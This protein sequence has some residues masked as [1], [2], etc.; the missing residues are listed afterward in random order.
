MKLSNP[1]KIDFDTKRN[2]GLDILRA[3]AIFFV[4][5]VHSA[6][7][8]KPD[9]RTLRILTIFNLDGVMLFFVLSGFLIG[10][11]L[12]RQFEKDK[13]N[14]KMLFKFWIRRWFR[15]LPNYFLVLTILVILGY[16]Y[17]TIVNFSAIKHY[18]Y[19]MANFD[20]AI[21]S[22]LFPESWS[23]AVEEWFYLLIP[24]FIFILV[25]LCRF[26]PK[27]SVLTVAVS[28]IVITTV[29]R[30]FRF[31]HMPGLVPTQIDDSFRKPVITRLDSLMFGV[32]GAFLAYYYLS[33]WKKYKKLLFFI[34]IILIYSNF[35]QYFG[36]FG[37]LY[38]S[39]FEYT[40][41]SVGFLCL[42]PYVTELKTGKG[43][44]YKIVTRTSIISYSLYLLNYS[45]VKYYI[46]E[47]LDYHPFKNIPTSYLDTVNYFSFW[48][49]TV[50]LAILLYKYFEKP[51]MD[52]RDKVKFS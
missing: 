36:Y 19:F 2:Y 6:N 22:Y 15:T 7:C 39:V 24:I 11:I 9:S 43:V 13:V 41:Q 51:V 40:V 10:G 31:L 27:T 52:L 17:K 5:N 12:I 34:G 3:F 45:V 21:P 50:S 16:Y 8:F 28:V 32:I 29:I 14:F 4:L 46:L 23:L 35:L 37:V 42:F 30:Y 44:I 38:N 26:K 1:F 20:T 25:A 49:I 33:A 47:Y 48:L 18:Y